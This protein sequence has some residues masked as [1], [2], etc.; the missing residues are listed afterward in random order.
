MS[1]RARS[2]QQIQQL[3]ALLFST[4]FPQETLTK[5]AVQTQLKTPHAVFHRKGH[6]LEKTF[7]KP[8]ALVMI[9]HH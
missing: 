9:L 6:S 5:M 7:K 3:Q 8:L 1:Q 4:L 2:S